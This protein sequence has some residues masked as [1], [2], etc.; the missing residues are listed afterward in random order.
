MVN[1]PRCGAAIDPSALACPYCQTQTL[2]GRQH[3]ERQAAHQYHAAQAQ[4]VQQ[5]AE[6]QSRQQALTKKGQAA[7]F[8]SIAA[9]LTCCFPAAIV[10]LVMGFNVKSAAKQEGAIAPATSTVAVVLG[11]CAIALFFV[12]VALYLND[13]R[14]RDA[15]ISALRAQ[16]ETV[17]ARDSIDQSLACAL[18]ELDLLQDGYL[19]KS[20]IMIEAFQCDGKL[21]QNKDAATLSDVRFR[22]SSSERHVVT[23]CLTHGAR[24][25]VKELR[26]DGSCAPRSAAAPSASAGP[27]P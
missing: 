12:M 16:V 18:V 13:S 14:T 19:D 15:R 8:W 1:C 22:T 27:S 9:T 4:Q 23:A 3:Q 24:W 6:R 26:T 21:E 20:G 2:Y 7:M 10:G 11:C 17:R 5:A 25:S